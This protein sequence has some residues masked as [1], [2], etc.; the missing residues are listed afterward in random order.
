MLLVKHGTI[1]DGTG[2]PGFKK[3]LLINNDRIVAIGDFSG[4]KN[5]EIIDALGCIVAPGFIDIHSAINDQAA[6][7]DTKQEA[8]LREGITSI[9]VGHREASYAGKTKTNMNGLRI[10]LGAQ[11]EYEPIRQIFYIPLL[12]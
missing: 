1:I 8:Y 7:N 9:I 4:K 12:T 3:D 6:Q 10:N 11:I 2:K 5:I